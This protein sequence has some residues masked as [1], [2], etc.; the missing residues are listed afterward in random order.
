MTDWYPITQYGAD[1]RAAEAND[2]YLHQRRAAGAKPSSC[3]HCSADVVAVFVS[4]A[5]KLLDQDG[6]E[7]QCEVTR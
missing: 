4:G 3:R 1:R 6:T 5:W 2:E 7:H